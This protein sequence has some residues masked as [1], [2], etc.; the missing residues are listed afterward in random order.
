MTEKEL[1]ADMRALLEAMDGQEA[2][3]AEHGKA[4]AATKGE[5][6]TPSPSLEDKIGQLLGAL[7][8]N[9]ADDWMG[10]PTQKE[11][12]MRFFTQPDEAVNHGE[13][14]AKTQ[15]GSDDTIDSLM[16]E[17]LGAVERVW[18]LDESASK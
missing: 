10:K 11:L 16:R 6:Q 2:S 14:K 12:G 5:L 13:A 4:E 9:D 1:V 8:S 15:K 18:R 7:R 3:P 17:Y